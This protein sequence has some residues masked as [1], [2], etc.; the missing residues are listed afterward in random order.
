MENPLSSLLCSND[1]KASSAMIVLRLDMSV[2]SR[3]CIS[4]IK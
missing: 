3:E 2:F 1:T 4:V